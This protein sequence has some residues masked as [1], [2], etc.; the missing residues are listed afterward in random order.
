M[1]RRT[2]D[3]N[4][5]G[6]VRASDSR[7]GYF[8]R[9]AFAPIFR[10]ADREKSGRAAL[11]IVDY[12]PRAMTT[13]RSVAHRV[14]IIGGGF[15]GLNAARELAN[16]RGVEVA[17]VD[18]ANHHL[19]QP[20]LYQVAT[21]G[22]S[23]A[24]IAAPLR[25]ILHEARNVRV[26][27]GDVRDFDVEKQRVLLADGELEYDTLIVASGSRTFYFGRDDWEAHAPG[28][29]DL[30]DATR[31]RSKVLSAFERAE[32][33]SE[34]AKR[35]ALTTFAIVGGGPTGVELAGALAELARDTLANDFRS[36]DPREARVILIEGGERLL[37]SYPPIL[38]ERAVR[39]LER[40]AVEIWLRAKVTEIDG[41]RVRVTRD[42][43]PL[44]LAAETVLWAAGVRASELGQK[45]AERAAAT[46]DKQGRVHVGADFA[47]AN[48][49]EILVV[50]DLAH[51]ENASGIALPGIAPIAM[52][53]GTHVGKLVLARLRGAKLAP[54]RYRDKGNMAVIGRSAAVAEIHGRTFS[55]Y[56]AW[57][58]WLF[59]HLMYLVGFANRVLVFFQWAWNYATHNRTARL[60]TERSER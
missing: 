7:R 47:L 1:Q 34:I 16:R 44:E 30:G 38:S 54:F 43:A 13:P 40:L 28:L 53:Q 11:A 27:L 5:G 60:I 35:R 33:E 32:R 58:L 22:L 49:P 2:R 48:H 19:F 46:L 55:G 57:L 29:K 51:F 9:R 15:A 8:H 52:Q 4:V 25:G 6:D 59:V 17:L 41:G 20:L 31:I 10:A 37:A 21:G 50:G 36:I 23:P 24:D 12:D 14:V 3:G 45:L 42:G 26:L 18:R 39:S 56:L